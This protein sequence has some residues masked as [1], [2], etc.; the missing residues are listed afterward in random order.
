MY[1]SYSKFRQRF[2]ESYTVDLGAGKKTG[3]T[4][5]GKSR[6]IA[7]E[8]EARELL[9]IT[10]IKINLRENIERLKK[11]KLALER[12]IANRQKLEEKIASARSLD[13]L[14]RHETWLQECIQKIADI[15]NS[16]RKIESWIEDDKNKLK[17][18][19][20]IQS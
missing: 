12:Q 4:R 14:R 3:N 1:K 16:I 8:K 6:K 15:E 17:K 11:S 2:K 10:G 20:G 19:L 7:A 5:K 9:K 13:F 18:I